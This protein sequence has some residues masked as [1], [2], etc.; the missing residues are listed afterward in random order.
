MYVTNVNV[1]NVA[2]RSKHEQRQWDMVAKQY[3]YSFSLK[4]MTFALFMGTMLG[5]IIGMMVGI[6]FCMR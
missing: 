3:P 1:R 6:G 2:M 5:F 4:D